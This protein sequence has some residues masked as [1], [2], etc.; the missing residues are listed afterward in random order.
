M[1]ET[2]ADPYASG[3]VRVSRVT[4]TFMTRLPVKIPVLDFDGERRSGRAQV[5]SGPPGP[6]KSGARD[7]EVKQKER[8]VDAL[9]LGADERRDKLR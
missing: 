8:R 7:D 5:R 9:A 1:T 6:N 2:T 4:R 3:S